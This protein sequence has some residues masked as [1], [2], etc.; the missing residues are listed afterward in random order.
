MEE[1][2]KKAQQY[3]F[4]IDE[5]YSPGLNSLKRIYT[6]H[7]KFNGNTR[8]IYELL[9]DHWNPEYGY[10]FPDQW[11]LARESGLS[12]ASVNNQIKI[13]EEL[14]LIRVEKTKVSTRT[15]NVYYLNKPV[16]TIEEF[17]SKFPEVKARAEE[18]IRKI[19]EE[20]ESLKQKKW[21]EKETKDKPKRRI[22]NMEVKPP[23]NKEAA[24]QSFDD[25]SSWL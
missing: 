3:P 17:Y 11:E 24:D 8:L 4:K 10:A 21:V 2:E 22:I 20:E 7:P 13:L 6:Q 18:R 23:K 12:R 14:D 25:V 19:D 5:Y 9:Y 1:K 16:T 15:N